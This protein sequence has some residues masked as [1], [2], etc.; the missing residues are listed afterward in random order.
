MNDAFLLYMME[1]E[2]ITDVVSTR[3][4]RINWA[5]NQVLGG[6]SLTII[7]LLEQKGIYE[8]ST[9]ENEYITNRLLED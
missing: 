3:M 9:T 7:E 1:A 5:I 8:L 6:S 2:G 4:A